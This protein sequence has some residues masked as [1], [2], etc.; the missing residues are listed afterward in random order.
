MPAAVIFSEHNRM[1]L[2]WLIFWCEIAAA[3]G[4]VFLGAVMVLLA[5]LLGWL[6]GARHDQ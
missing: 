6:L 2:P 1:A 3:A 4:L 5:A